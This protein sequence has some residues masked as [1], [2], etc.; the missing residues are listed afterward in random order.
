MKFTLKQYLANDI[1]EGFVGQLQEENILGILS[2]LKKK[3][4]E[5]LKEEEQLDGQKVDHYLKIVAIFEQ[6]FRFIQAKKIDPTELIGFKRL[7]D[8]NGMDHANENEVE[9]GIE[10]ILNTYNDNHFVNFKAI[11]ER[12]FDDFKKWFVGKNKE[13]LKIVHDAIDFTMSSIQN[14]SQAAHIAS[15]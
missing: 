3:L 9:R 11:V 8:N 14:Y 7:V 10:K 6:F 4:I 12:R 15:A 13:D 5:L 2:V 1:F